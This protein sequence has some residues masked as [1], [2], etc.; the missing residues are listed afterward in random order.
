MFNYFLIYISNKCIVSFTDSVGSLG[1][2]SLVSLP[3]LK[4]VSFGGFSLN[5]TMATLIESNIFRNLEELHFFDSSLQT[6]FL[7]TFG[8]LTSL[9]RLDFSGCEI[10]SGNLTP[11]K[12]PLHLKNLESLLILDTFLEN[13]FLQNIGAMPSL[14]ILRLQRCGIKGTLS[15]QGF[16]ELTNLQ[17][18]DINYNNLMGSLPECFSKLTFLENLDL[19]FNLISGNIFALKNLKSLRKLNLSNNYFEI[20]RSLGPLFNLS[21][22]HHI[23]ADNNTIY[24]ETEMHSVAPTFQLKYINLSCCG[25]GGTF[26]QFLYRQHDLWYVD[27]FNINFIGEFSNWLL[28]NN[29]KLGTLILTNNS[30]WGHFKLPFFLHKYLSYLDISK[31]SLYGNIPNEIGAKLPSLLFLNMSKNSFGGSIPV[32]IGDMNSLYTLDLSNNKLTSG[33][34]EHLA[35]GCSSLS[36]LLLS[37]NRLQ[38]KIFSSNCNLINLEEL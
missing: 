22:L 30:P 18:L 28:E 36:F 35:M 24:A 6:N 17:I 8:Q 27:L 11:P 21:K 16:C 14:K 34:P 25:V 26:P 33:V 3:S 20:P 12:G 19:S 13:N 10:N 2:Q 29:T 32:S 37:N 23:H 9:R 31:N 5:E 38:G 4:T 7:G 15:T 1:Q